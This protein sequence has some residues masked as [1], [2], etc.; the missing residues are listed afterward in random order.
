MST[1]LRVPTGVPETALIVA[2]WGDNHTWDVENVTVAHWQS[3]CAEQG[4]RIEKRR[5]AGTLYKQVVV[6]H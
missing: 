5:K 6:F 2:V 1:D 4:G 3:M